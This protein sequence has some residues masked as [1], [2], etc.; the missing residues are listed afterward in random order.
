MNRGMEFHYIVAPDQDALKRLMGPYGKDGWE[1]VGIVRYTYGSA[2]ASWTAFMQRELPRM[3][4]N[5]N[6]PVLARSGVGGE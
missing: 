2:E 6:R 5:R 1:C 3:A 4:P